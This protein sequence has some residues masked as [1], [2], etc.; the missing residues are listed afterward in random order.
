MATRYGVEVS[1]YAVMSNHLHV[2]LRTRPDWV[3]SWSNR[4]VAIRWL[5]LFSRSKLVEDKNTPPRHSEIKMLTG[6]EEQMAELRM[7]LSSVSWFM[8]SLNEYHI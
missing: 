6:N 2:V 1:V 7:R 3:D 5:K 8:R 4:E